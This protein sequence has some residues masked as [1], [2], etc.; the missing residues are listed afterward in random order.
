M[1]PTL[2]L[3]EATKC[4]A[5]LSGGLNITVVYEDAWS[6]QWAGHVCERVSGLVGSDSLRTT[7][8]KMADLSEPAVLAGAVSTAMRADVLVVALRAA[9]GLPLP[10]YVW[11]D[12]WLPYH[13]PG[14][15]ALVALI[16]MP[17]NP[18]PRL[19]RA[20]NYLR[21]VAGHGGLD[22][23][24]QER[25]EPLDWSEPRSLGASTEIASNP[26]RFAPPPLERRR[27]RTSSKRRSAVAA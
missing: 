23:M 26:Q 9:E 16:T 6:R 27:R 1:L 8:W 5:A 25:K 18:R 15:A 11:V 17:D 2:P 24:I 20:R 7:W 22:F 14:G 12:S 13:P 21:A 19:D 10:F 3:P 4:A